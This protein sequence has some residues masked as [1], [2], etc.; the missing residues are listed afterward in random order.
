[1]DTFKLY[2]TWHRFLTQWIPDQCASRVTNLTLLIV[3]LYQAR[4]V[5]TGLIVRTWPVRAKL[6]SLSRRV[7]RFLDNPAVVVRDWYAPLASQLLAMLAK[8][9]V[10]LII[11]A[12]RVGFGH[13][14]LILALA[15]RRR[16][17]PLVWSWK[18][19][20]RGHSS[21]E[22]QLELLRWVHDRLPP[23][24]QVVLVGD[25]EFAGEKLLKQVRRWHWRYVLRQRGDYLVRR[26]GS[27]TWQPFAALL[28]HPGQQVWWPEAV[29]T[30][31]AQLN[32]ALLAYWQP[33]ADEPWLLATNLPD[34]RRTR[35]AYA[36]RMWIEEMFGDLKGHGFDLQ[37]THLRHEQR[38]SR[39]T[40]AVC[41]LYVWLLLTGHQ[42][43]KAGQRHLVDRHDRRDLSHFR[44]G[45]NFIERCLA[46]FISVP[47]SLPAS[48]PPAS[49]VSGG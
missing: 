23:G 18:R 2:G 12:S 4:H 22:K 48:I 5:H 31:T 27:R 33:G 17:L 9:E 21:G 47:V 41:L 24:A 34:A 42:V 13:Q 15:Y 11:D 14:W 6:A 1:M 29:L 20:K 30:Q 32:T 8:G 40:L 39:L 35:Q 38:L 37:A 3:G 44:I 45:W 7:S 16:A 46:W 28:T 25:S 43:V 49:L 10:R 26:K 36:R 19:G